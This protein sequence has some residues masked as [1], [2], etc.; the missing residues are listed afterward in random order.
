MD[1][2]IFSQF[3]AV[4]L[5]QPVAVKG[6]H[7]WPE[8]YK[9]ILEELDRCASHKSYLT[10]FKE[11]PSD[12][13]TFNT[14]TF[15]VIRDR[16]KGTDTNLDIVN[17]ELV[18]NTNKLH[19]KKDSLNKTTLYKLQWDFKSYNTLKD[20]KIPEFINL[21]NINEAKYKSLKDQFSDF[22][23]IPVGLNPS[24]Y[25]LRIAN[26]NKKRIRGLCSILEKIE[27]LYKTTYIDFTNSITE[28]IMDTI[29]NVPSFEDF[30]SI[31]YNFE[32]LSIG[33][34]DHSPGLITKLV[35]WIWQ[36]LQDL[37]D[38][39]T[40]FVN[41][42][43]NFISRL[44]QKI[45]R[46]FK[47]RKIT[48]SQENVKKLN[49]WLESKELKVLPLKDCDGFL[50]LHKSILDNAKEVIVSFVHGGKTIPELIKEGIIKIPTNLTDKGKKIILEGKIEE[51]DTVKGKDILNFIDSTNKIDIETIKDDNSTVQFYNGTIKSL[52]YQI[53]VMEKKYNPIIEQAK[54]S[55]TNK[56]IEKVL[57]SMSNNSIDSKTLS[58]TTTAYLTTISFV[59][60]LI[61]VNINRLIPFYNEFLRKFCEFF[62]NN[63]QAILVRYKD[64]DFIE[65]ALNKLRP[66]TSIEEMNFYKASDLIKVQNELGYSVQF[67][68][69]EV[70]K[71]NAFCAICD[72]G[73]KCIGIIGDGLI[74]TFSRKELE[75]ILGHEYGHYLKT[76]NTSDILA[77]MK[78]ILTG[79]ELKRPNRKLRYELEAD[80]YGAKHT[81]PTTMLNAL[82]IFAKKYPELLQIS[83]ELKLRLNYLRIWVETK[84]QPDLEE[85][86]KK[87]NDP[88]YS[89]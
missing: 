35:K 81:D 13:N 52:E 56:V 16:L 9:Y 64:P 43:I 39:I 14:S 5:R 67:G 26:A 45:K 53:E 77:I 22:Q 44:L 4:P 36:K 33:L 62:L 51:I 7:T 73:S 20:V 49:E 6:L 29:D 75:A 61:Q 59:L 10:M 18:L 82:L 50:E 63:E 34:E 48:Y 74:K 8:L 15:D 69:H 3:K 41:R 23:L 57:T 32:Y 72:L 89:N 87:H 19:Y 24:L 71:N 46:Y 84:Q 21:I 2:K 76:H 79:K 31:D 17:G 70:N 25:D 66:Y 58:Q 12:T 65:K 27:E 55:N 11:S 42:V 37:W 83:N 38:F 80:I 78:S 68:A 47:S 54:K 40:G 60:K 88:E 1:E 28:Q 30:I 86:L 85:Y